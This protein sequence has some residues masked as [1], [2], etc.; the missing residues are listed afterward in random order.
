LPDRE[1]RRRAGGATR[2]RDAGAAAALRWWGDALAGHLPWVAAVRR[3]NSAKAVAAL[4]WR[5]RFSPMWAID[6]TRIVAAMSPKIIN[7]R[8]PNVQADGDKVI[9]VGRLT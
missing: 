8:R 7:L 6:G 2:R 5:R 9:P 4:G 1:A 3:A